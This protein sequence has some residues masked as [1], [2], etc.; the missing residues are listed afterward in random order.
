MVTNQQTQQ[1]Q[2]TQ[3]LNKLNNLHLHFGIDFDG[4]VYRPPTPA[5]QGILYAGPQKLL[6]WLEAQLGLSGP[7]A[8]TAYLR[9]EMYRQALG[10]HL[11]EAVAPPFYALSF[12]ADRF[13]VATALLEWRDELLLAGW[14]FEAKQDQPA[15]LQTLAAVEILYRNKTADP[16]M[17][18]QTIGIADR[19]TAVIDKFKTRTLP[20]I[21]I[22]LY[23]PEYLYPPHIQ[24]LL[25]AAAS[26]GI[27]IHPQELHPAAPE[28]TDLGRF[29]RFLT[30][31]QNTETLKHQN[32]ETPKHQNTK[33]LK[34]QNTNIL[35]AHARHDTS[36]ARHLA[37]LLRENPAVKPLLLLPDLNLL[38]DQ[39]LALE[40]FPA[41]GLQSA[42]L[43]RP[44]L[45][46]LKLAPV[47]LWEPTDIHKIMEFA[48]LPLKPLETGLAIEIARVL[49]QKPGLFN[50]NWFAAVFGYL[51]REETSDNARKQYEFW[52]ERR[53]YRAESTAPLRDVIEIYAFL[54]TWA[55]EYYEET[56]SKNSSLLVL[57]SQARRIKELLEAL[58]EPRIGFLDLERIVRT[59]Y[60]PSPVQLGPAEVD[61]FACIHVPGAIV[62]PAE[63][64]IWCNYRF[65]QN[66]PPPDKWQ[67]TERHYL[68]KQGIIL[69]KPTDQS[70]LNLLRQYRP[71]LMASKQLLIVAPE[72]VEGTAVPPG[73]LLGDIESFFG[74][75]LHQMTFRLDDPSGDERLKQLFRLPDPEWLQ[76][77][78][79]NRTP[80]QLR[81]QHPEYLP[82]S[83]YETP[84]NLESLFY[85]PH[86]WLFRKLRLVPTGLL[87]ITSDRALLGN[88]AHRFFEMLLQEDFY[89]M[90]KRALQHWI[91]E[92][93]SHLLVR[94]GAT[95]LLYG[96][97][98][99]RNIFLKR[100]KHAAWTLVEL[101]R[102]NNWT[103]TNTE[104]DLVG[105]FGTVP[106]KG[107]ADI[108][109]RRG[110]E[111]AI[112]DLKWGGANHRKDLIRNGEDLQ[113]VLYADLLEPA[114]YWPHTAYFILEDG[115]M[116]ARN[117]EAFRE[118]LTATSNPAPSAEVCAQI[119][120]RMRSTYQ[121]RMD[122]LRRGVVEL[123]TARTASEL[124]A[125]YEG[126]MMEVLEMKQEDA[127]WDEYRT[128]LHF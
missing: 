125:L 108:V 88:L 21:A 80:P 27:A 60:E 31:S 23:E 109:L 69:Q 43:A 72:Y 34:H 39:H 67:E 77:R 28:D 4:T 65:V 78:L 106:V 82:E 15:R 63:T 86:R 99:E 114:G 13:A 24:R 107:K 42:S 117:A 10:Q 46:A 92:K 59:V 126:E 100:V 12:D 40:G 87:S 53:R 118:A 113:L 6:H 120:Q 116:I 91:D 83:E 38:M 14:L 48:T 121:W 26:Q 102:D 89:K 85:Y 18:A 75:A 96:R 84:T 11:V 110:N 93:A 52:F 62:A 104:L 119:L 68:E 7:V 94:E 98:P 128:L 56:G 25:R 66:A 2:Q 73:P 64:V 36:A 70:R 95:L 54:E 3:P 41:L 124:E 97:E 19:Y 50:D 16:G 1:T 61:S 79:L 122:Q 105:T 49:A 22:Y 37:Q 8:N 71:V 44:S 74:A 115:K 81:L 55:R 32:T 33:T 17:Y 127:K 76:P 29:Q 30:A 58:P 123:R 20:T 35:I 5:R 112:I 47:F 90:D 101:L 51:E 57:G 103:V 45:Q 111:W 9:I